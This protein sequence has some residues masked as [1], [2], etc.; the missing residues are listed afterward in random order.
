MNLG[1]PR[2]GPG[3]KYTLGDAVGRCKIT[4]CIYISSPE[5]LGGKQ[6]VPNCTSALFPGFQMFSVEAPR[7]LAL[8]AVTIECLLFL[9]RPQTVSRWSCGFLL[10]LHSHRGLKGFPW[11]SLRV[12]ATSPRNE[13][14]FPALLLDPLP[15]ASVFFS[16]ARIRASVCWPFR[17]PHTI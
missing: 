13:G 3:S 15:H 8:V 6:K 16:R 14:I 10:I 5:S 11:A 17:D 2:L 1:L 7:C 12:E 9:S 4:D